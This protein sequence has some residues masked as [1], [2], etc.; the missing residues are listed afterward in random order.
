MVPEFYG[1]AKWF[2]PL[3]NPVP[4]LYLFFINF[5]GPLMTLAGGGMGKNPCRL[6]TSGRYFVHQP[7]Q[8]SPLQPDKIH[9]I[10]S[11]ISNPEPV[12]TDQDCRPA[13]AVRRDK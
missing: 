7:R 2:Q 3:K 5:H 11:P 9:F 12:V 10:A 1:I 4:P 13:S 6:L 8:E